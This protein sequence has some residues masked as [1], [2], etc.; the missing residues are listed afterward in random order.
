MVDLHKIVVNHY[1]EIESTLL[2][3]ASGG[4]LWINIAWYMYTAW[5]GF[6]GLN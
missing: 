2:E 5:F 3:F 6:L 1:S 4:K